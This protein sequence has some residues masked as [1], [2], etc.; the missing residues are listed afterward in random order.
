MFWKTLVLMLISNIPLIA[1]PISP[2]WPNPG[3]ANQAL[4]ALDAI[5][6][7]HSTMSII[8]FPDSF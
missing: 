4:S 1:I 2:D 3:L 5:N 8:V 7:A 6:P